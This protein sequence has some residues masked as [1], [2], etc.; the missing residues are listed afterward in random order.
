MSV[1][2]VKWRLLHDT[3]EKTKY[4]EH[5]PNAWIPQKPLLVDT[6]GLIQSS[7][8][9]Q[10]TILSC[11]ECSLLISPFGATLFSRELSSS[12]NC[13]KLP[14]RLP[15]PHPNQGTLSPLSILWCHSHS[16]AHW[17]AEVRFQQKLHCT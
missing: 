14:G 12:R 15:T 2:G 3:V 11:Y 13:P 10:Y 7:L 16:R 1:T 9:D 6:V 5:W 4:L 8:F 17:Q